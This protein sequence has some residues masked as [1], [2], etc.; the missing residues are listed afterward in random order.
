[1]CVQIRMKAAGAYFIFLNSAS[2]DWSITGSGDFPISPTLQSQVTPNWACSVPDN[3]SLPNSKILRLYRVA[4]WP[5][6]ASKVQPPGFKSARKESSY[7]LNNSHSTPGIHSDWTNLVTTTTSHTHSWSVARV[8][9]CMIGQAL[10][11]F[12]PQCQAQSLTWSMWTK[13]RMRFSI[14]NAG[15]CYRRKDTE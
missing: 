13:R 4:R 10:V 3:I 14:I 1:M 12:H 6:I 9:L 15:G 11:R 8:I 5:S 2:S 7:R